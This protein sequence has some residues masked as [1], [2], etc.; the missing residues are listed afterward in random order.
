MSD[1][2]KIINDIYFDR[3]GFGSRGTTL[4]DAK[5]KDSSIKCQMLRGSLKR[6]LK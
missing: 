2:Q 5:E 4:K 3:S 6:M 1:K